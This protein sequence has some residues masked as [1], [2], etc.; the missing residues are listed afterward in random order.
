MELVL[1]TTVGC[2]LCDKAKQIVEPLK[3]SHNLT[4]KEIDIAFDDDLMHKYAESIPVLY[5]EINKMEL[6]WPFGLL[7]VVRLAS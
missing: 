7:D 2:H 1:Y 5:N 3:T 6:N 4:L